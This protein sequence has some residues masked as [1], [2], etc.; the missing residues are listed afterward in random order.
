MGLPS[1]D[2]LG[3]PATALAT[4]VAINAWRAFPFAM[5]LILAALQTIDNDVLARRTW[6][7][8]PLAGVHPY[9]AAAH[10]EPRYSS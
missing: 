8:P 6:T 7:A 1:L 9:H 10:L 2:L 4:V 3:T 5:V